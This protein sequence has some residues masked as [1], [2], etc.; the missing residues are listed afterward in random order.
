MCI[1][2]CVLYAGCVC[3]SVKSAFSLHLYMGS[4]DPTQGT[5]CS[6]KCYCPVRDPGPLQL[7]FEKS[8]YH[9]IPI[10][11]GSMSTPAPSGYVQC[12]IKSGSKYNSPILD[13]VFFQMEHRILLNLSLP[14]KSNQKF[15]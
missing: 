1:C 11:S 4:V 6:S 10:L 12:T 7:S 13:P 14:L 9:G 3:H 2:V 15:D 5:H 8:L